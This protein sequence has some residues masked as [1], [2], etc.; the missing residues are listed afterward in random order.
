MTQPAGFD[1]FWS[2][3]RLLGEHGLLQHVTL[4]GSWAEYIYAQSNLL[5]GFDANLRTLDI[6]FLV[7]NRKRP[8]PGISL[9][10]IAQEAGYIIDYDTLTEA[11][12]IYSPGGMEIEF[13]VH[14]LGL[15]DKAVLETNL[16]VN[17]QALRHLSMLKDHA[18]AVSVFGF[19]VLVPLPEAYALHKLIIQPMRGKKREKDKEALHSLLPYLDPQVFRAIFADLTKNERKTVT[20]QKEQFPELLRLLAINGQS[21]T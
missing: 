2:F 8:A 5:P 21:N 4:I 20:D 17:A 1:D 12:K 10:G 15:G 19:D 14:Q 3:I 16:G 13:L 9:A 18:R 7:R 6:D 11:T